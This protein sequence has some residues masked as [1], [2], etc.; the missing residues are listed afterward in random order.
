[1]QPAS[2]LLFRYII[3]L[4]LLFLS[5][6][7]PSAA[8]A[9]CQPAI[10]FDYIPPFGS[11]EDLT[12]RVSC[13]D[14][15][16]Y[17]AAVYI[18]VNGWWTKPTFATPLTPIQPDGT[19]VTDITT[20]GSDQFATEIA[21]FLVPA[22]FAPPLMSG[23]NVLPDALYA[24]AAAYIF[25]T[26]R[27]ARTIRFSGYTWEVKYT[28]VR[29]GPGENYFSDDP[30]SV[31][32]D[33]NGYLHLAV[34]QREGI[35][36]CAEVINTALAGYGEHTIEVGS[37]VDLLDKNVVFGYFTWDG[38]APEYSYREIDIEFSRWGTDT[39][40]NAQYVIQPWDAA[41]NR[42]RFD[43]SLPG[44]D[45]KHQFNWLPGSVMFDSWDGNGAPLQTWTYTNPLYLK[46][47]GGNIRLN[48]WLLEGQ[49][50]SDGQSAEV[51]VKSYR[52]QPGP[53]RI[54][55]PAAIRGGG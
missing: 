2:S 21:V 44:P 4:L 50:P 26:R 41:G 53:H 48:L 27:A 15:A 23:G 18:N 37:R 10:V 46:P 3:I 12:G 8:P 36:Y 31:W 25:A 9:D 22:G 5:G 52:Y 17:A 29:S 55:L 13:A 35:W 14:P 49:V 1:M 54:Y 45:S 16:G 40:P 28:P 24:G 7:A 51:I 43:L 42:R 32:V 38:Q 39:D 34:V 33:E 30:E 11:F 20:G 47:A 6:K 19:W